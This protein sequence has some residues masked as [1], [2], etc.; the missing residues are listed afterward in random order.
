MKFRVRAVQEPRP[1][2]L[3]EPVNG[4]SME[5]AMSHPETRELLDQLMAVLELKDPRLVSLECEAA[6]GASVVLRRE[7]DAARAG[8]RTLRLTM[9]AAMS[10]LD[11][12]NIPEAQILLHAGLLSTPAFDEE[13]A[14]L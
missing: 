8:V 11:A 10:A 4:R 1:Q 14:P 7:R 12:E 5:M 6:L 2:V 3:I 13:G 9:K